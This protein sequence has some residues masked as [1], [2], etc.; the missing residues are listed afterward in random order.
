[1][2]PGNFLPPSKDETLNINGRILQIR[3]GGIK[4]RV[5]KAALGSSNLISNSQIKLHFTLCRGRK[6]LVRAGMPEIRDFALWPE[7]LLE[8]LETQ[9]KTM[10]LSGEKRDL[11][12]QRAAFL[13]SSLCLEAPSLPHPTPIP[14]TPNQTAVL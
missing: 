4:S 10:G 2:S 3:A 1:M 9:H 5:F 12:M 14:Q 13:C 7:T 11:Q 6:L 8:I